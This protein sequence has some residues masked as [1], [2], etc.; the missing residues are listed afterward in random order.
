MRLL[1]G[2]LPRQTLSRLTR[3]ATK[4]KG[5]QPGLSDRAP[6]RAG[7]EI[8]GRIEQAVHVTT[9]RSKTGRVKR[10]KDQSRQRG[11]GRRRCRS[12]QR[13]KLAFASD[14]D[15]EKAADVNR[16]RGPLPRI[17]KPLCSR[18]HVAMGVPKH[19]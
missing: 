13:K 3:P 5:T 7:S 16:P 10:G 17:V 9:L 11:S 12:E 8:G 19:R 4:R 18:E 2:R 14:I 1:V 15:P 6:N